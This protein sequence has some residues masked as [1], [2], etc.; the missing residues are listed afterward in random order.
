MLHP[1]PGAPTVGVFC[2]GKNRV[3]KI[4]RSSTDVVQRFDI[5][6]EQRLQCGE[7]RV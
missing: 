3:V 7:Q 5:E 1:P 2:T 4:V 6:D